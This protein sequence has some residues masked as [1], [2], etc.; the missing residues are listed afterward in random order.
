MLKAI[1]NMKSE[2]EIKLVLSYFADL[3]KTKSNNIDINK[4][5][6][7]LEHSFVFNNPK[8]RDAI[9]EKAIDMQILEARANQAKFIFSVIPKEYRNDLNNLI[10]EIISDPEQ[11]DHLNGL[12]GLEMLAEER[13]VKFPNKEEVEKII[14][15]LKG[16]NQ[17][18]HKGNVKNME[19]NMSIINEI[20]EIKNKL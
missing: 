19:I 17:Q 20:Q 1:Q 3:I 18:M 16:V 2:G 5:N 14:N 12:E 11:R 15:E 7:L 10:D 8:L 4:L 6:N 9:L 13:N